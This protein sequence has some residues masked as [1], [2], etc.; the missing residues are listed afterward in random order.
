MKSIRCLVTYN[1][2]SNTA[3]AKLMRCFTAADEHIFGIYI[4]H[5]IERYTRENASYRP[6][7][8]FPGA[9]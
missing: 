7:A 5:D 3:I 1:A 9:T 2:K 6:S 4:A 8:K